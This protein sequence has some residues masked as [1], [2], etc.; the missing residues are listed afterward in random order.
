MRAN[1]TSSWWPSAAPSVWKRAADKA[2]DT[3]VPIPGS[4]S[5]T[6]SRCTGLPP[7]LDGDPMGAV[8][9]YE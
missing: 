2:R 5:I 7:L 6:T 8:C 9:S 3:T 4:S 1:G